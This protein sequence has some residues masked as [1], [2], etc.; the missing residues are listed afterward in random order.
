MSALENLQYPIGRYKPHE[1]SDE[2]K[3]NYLQDIANTPLAV[4][5][6]IAGLS[7]S[8]LDTP[9]RLGGWT[10]RQV[11]HHLPD[12]HMNAYIRCKWAFTEEEPLIKAYFEERWA[13]TAEAQTAEPELSLLL[14]EALHK[15]WVRFLRSLSNEQMEKAFQHPQSGKTVSIRQML[16]L[17]AWHGKHHVA[18]ITSLRER[19]KW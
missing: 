16:G 19:M 14:L 5:E 2:I 4:R 13:E 11:I 15:R 10:I 18:H 9:Y 3:E 1:I 12:S 6:A 17:Y 8:Q 7:D